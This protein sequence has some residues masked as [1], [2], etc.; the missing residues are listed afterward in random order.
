MLYAYKWK[1]LI[2]PSKDS[3]CFS[4]LL[5]VEGVKIQIRTN[6][7]KILLPGG[8]YIEIGALQI[9]YYGQLD[10]ERKAA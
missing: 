8:Q 3:Y 1:L 2:F 6:Y 5:L 10:L 7:N 4:T 9:L